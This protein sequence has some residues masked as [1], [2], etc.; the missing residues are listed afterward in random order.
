MLP[1]VYPLLAPLAS[2]RVYRH[3]QAPQ[4]VTA[5]YITW[6]VFG[7]PENNFDG[8]DND[9]LRV[10]V[11]CWSNDDAEVETLGTDVRD[12]MEPHAHMTL[13]ETSAD[14]GRFRMT[15]QFDWIALR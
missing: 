15:L 13:F 6:S 9:R 7:S 4:N 2:G 11:D 8:A 1:P 12:A 5:P 14:S 10:Q 3:G